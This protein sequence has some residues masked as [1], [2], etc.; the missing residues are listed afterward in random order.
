MH[1]Q[2]PASAVPICGT[3]SHSGNGAHLAEPATNLIFLAMI[4]R[5]CGSRFCATPAWLSKSDADLAP[6]YLYGDNVVMP[7]HEGLHKRE[8]ISIN[9]KLLAERYMKQFDKCWANA[10]V[11][12]KAKG[13]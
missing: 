3:R 12:K 10:S 7:L 9:S 1:G 5:F 8:W 13:K 11:P 4:N 6:F 2:S